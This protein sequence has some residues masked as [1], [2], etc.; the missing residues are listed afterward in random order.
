MKCYACE[1]NDPMPF[2][3]K[4]CKHHFCGDHRLPEDH[5]CPGL[6]AYKEKKFKELRQGIEVSLVYSHPKLRKS[7]WYQP[8]LDRVE[9]NPNF[10][11]GVGLLIILFLMMLF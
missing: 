11:L 7:K 5:D 3:C 9:S 8:L 1:S 2:K 10:Y 6:Q 4:F